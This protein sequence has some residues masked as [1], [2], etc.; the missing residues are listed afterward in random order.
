M[1]S[2]SIG[3]RAAKVAGGDLDQQLRRVVEMRLELSEHQFARAER[4]AARVK[5]SPQTF[6]EIVV[7]LAL[8]LGEHKYLPAVEAAM[9]RQA[10]RRQRHA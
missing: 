8:D 2:K 1:P 3:A 9:A 10:G 5:Q 6:M 7:A 4:L